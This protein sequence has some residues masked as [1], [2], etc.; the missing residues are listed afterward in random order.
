MIL[1]HV[2]S[3]NVLIIR[4]NM[5]SKSRFPYR[6]FILVALLCC[7]CGKVFS[8]EKYNIT[9]GAGLPES[10]NVGIWYQFKNSQA[11]GT[12]GYMPSPYTPY[13]IIST[14]Y[15]THFAGHTELSNRQPWYMRFGLDYMRS[16]N[17]LW[18]KEEG[19]LN[20]RVGR[21]FNFTKRVGFSIDGGLVFWLLHNSIDKHPQPNKWNLDAIIPVLPTIGTR[22]FYRL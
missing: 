21:D 12:I 18:I 22:F 16:E 2:S 6:N 15:I 14:A 19:F 13:V 7:T 3:T 4:N 1:P 8:Q 9:V 10:F 5:K 17:S 20:I 11:G